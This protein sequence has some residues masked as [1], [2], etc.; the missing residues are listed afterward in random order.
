MRN[1]TKAFAMGILAIAIVVGTLYAEEISLGG[2][3]NNKLAIG[4]A[5]PES[6]YAVAW[7]NYPVSQLKG[8][9]EENSPAHAHL[10][11]SYPA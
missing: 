8:P 7:A 6:L 4:D 2:F 5:E 10:G 11:A 9:K 3:V 1:V